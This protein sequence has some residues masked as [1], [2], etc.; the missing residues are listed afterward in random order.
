FQFEEHTADVQ[1]K[2]WGSTLEEAFCQTA[3]SLMKTI[4][5]NL[6]LIQDMQVL[7]I[8]IEAEDLK[9]LLFDFLSEFLYIFDVKK[10]I[11]KTIL[12]Q[13]IEKVNKKYHLVAHLKGEKFDREKHEI[14]TEVKAITYSYMNIEKVNDK[15]QIN[16]VFD[17]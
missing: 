9:A 3:L 6:D 11:F 14:G 1:V 16:I 5:P 2:A 4:S 8:Q 12:V 17:I 13:R 15:Y 10:L 7:D